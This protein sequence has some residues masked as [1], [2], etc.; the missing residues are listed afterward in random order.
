MTSYLHGYFPEEQERLVEQAGIL[1]SLIYP[2]IDFEGC[3]HVLEIGSG[4]GAQTKVLISLFPDLKIT[5]VDA[6]S[7][8]LEKAKANLLEEADR[9][10][11]V[12]QDAQKLD[13]DEKFDGA[14]LCWVLEHIPD[15]K[16]VLGSLKNQ[17]LPGSVVWITEVFNSTFYFQPELP[18]LRNYYDNYNAYQR[19]LGGD[20]DVGAKLGG[21]LKE[22]GFRDIELYPGGFH[23]SKHEPELLQKFTTYWIE[24]MKSGAAAMLASEWILPEEVSA[25]EKDLIRI[26][27]DENAVF[28]Y[29]FVQASAT[30]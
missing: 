15:P 21:L 28:Y 4:V 3:K 17:L 24:L 29:R 18:G 23:L 20:P 27:A 26:A 7:K 11:F 6:E 1:G 22:N 13:L 25:M 2:R 30:I 9:L 16:S 14:F 19:S 10:T 8:Q 12:H 5:C